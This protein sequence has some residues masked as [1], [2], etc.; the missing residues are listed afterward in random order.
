MRSTVSRSVW[1]DAASSR[2]AISRPGHPA[3]DAKIDHPVILRHNTLQTPALKIKEFHDLTFMIILLIRLILNL[4]YN[5]CEL[6]HLRA[7]GLQRC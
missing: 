3:R 6:C 1:Y 4:I 2:N 5:Y 7:P